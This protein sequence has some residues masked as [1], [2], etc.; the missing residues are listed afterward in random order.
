MN[1]SMMI[2]SKCKTIRIFQISLALN[3]LVMVLMGIIINI[4][5]KIRP[6]INTNTWARVLKRSSIR[7]P[8]ARYQNKVLKMQ[9]QQVI[10]IQHIETLLEKWQ[11]IQIFKQLAWYQQ[12]NWSNL[13]EWT[14]WTRK[15]SW[16]SKSSFW[17]WRK[18]KFISSWLR[19]KT[20]ILKI[21]RLHP[22]AIQQEMIS[23]INPET[24]KN[25]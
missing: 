20:K 21:V 13:K 4:K 22:W 12:M 14:I 24:F 18:T 2:S 7:Q 10:L 5:D 1:M 3:K 25:S 16:Q 23:K 17:N 15:N 8:I 6:I 11:L 19:S 9:V